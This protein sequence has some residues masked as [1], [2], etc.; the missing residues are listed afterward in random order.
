M[1]CQWC[2]ENGT[3]TGVQGASHRDNHNSATCRWKKDNQIDNYERDINE[4]KK[5]QYDGDNAVVFH[6]NREVD[7]QRSNDNC[8]M[9][10]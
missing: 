6:N 8:C 1:T 4:R 7:Y 2:V 3:G 9:I 10:S 5:Y